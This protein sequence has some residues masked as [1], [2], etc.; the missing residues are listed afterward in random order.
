ML[1]ITLMN[2]VQWT[3]SCRC[4]RTSKVWSSLSSAWYRAPACITTDLIRMIVMWVRIEC[5]PL[6][7]HFCPGH[8][9]VL[10]MEHQQTLLVPCVFNL[11]YMCKD[12]LESVLYNRWLQVIEH[13][14]LSLQSSSNWPYHLSITCS[15]LFTLL[16]IRHLVVCHYDDVNMYLALQCIY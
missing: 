7:T 4:I 6:R 13:K 11:T 12:R 9:K 10:D 16:S 8:L 5:Q 15:R 1:L 3:W 14:E 2:S